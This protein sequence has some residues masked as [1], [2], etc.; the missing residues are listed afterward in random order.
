MAGSTCE[1]SV[2]DIYRG[3][4]AKHGRAQVVTE[5]VHQAIQLTRGCR[6]YR[7]NTVITEAGKKTTQQIDKAFLV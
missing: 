6:V 5:D 3:W 1:A 7:Q 4:A 2:G